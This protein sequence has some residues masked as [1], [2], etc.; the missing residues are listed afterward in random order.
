MDRLAKEHG[1]FSF[2]DLQVIS[3]IRAVD[4]S[5]FRKMLLEL[6]S[7]VEDQRALWQDAQ[8]AL[9]AGGFDIAYLATASE[10]REESRCPC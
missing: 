5:A 8:S 7:K 10:I 9:R 2:I 3:R 1:L 4:E 6:D